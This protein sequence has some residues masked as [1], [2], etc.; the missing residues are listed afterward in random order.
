MMTQ[1]L[2]ILHDAYREL[3]AK[4]LFWFV[5]IISGVVVIAFAGTGINERGITLFG[6]EFQSI[7]TTSLIARAM[8][9]KYLFSQLGIGFWLSWCAMILAL[10]STASIFPDFLAGGSIDLYLSRPISRLRLFLTKY[11]SGLLFVALQVGVFTFAC[12]LVIGMRGGAW[13]P[14]IFLAIPLVLLV[15]SYLF[16]IC[17]LLGLVTRSAIASLLLTCLVWL[18]I[19]GVDAAEKT[20]LSAKIAGDIETT[21]YRNTF[22]FKDKQIAQAKERLAKGDAD[23]KADVARLQSER[24]ALEE[25]K[26]KSD[27]GRHNWLIAHRLLLQTKTF[28]PKTSETNGLID[29]WLNVTDE[30]GEERAER[31][32]RRRASWIPNFGDRTQ[33][34]LDDPE[35]A[36][37]AADVVRDRPVLWV[38]GTSVAFEAVV[39][40]V[41]AWIFCRRDF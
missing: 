33:V 16:S 9:Y 38:L 30:I 41:S 3:N 15:F 21:A 29:R 2:A 22:E 37:E 8:W 18:M 36:R 35:V 39:L 10:V 25:K 26:R 6:L 23:A 31:R 14:K 27:P 34:R 11:V 7:I 5:L 19:F 40:G 12:F 32:Q 28:F 13:E 20:A 17:V 1:T 4:K 24:Q